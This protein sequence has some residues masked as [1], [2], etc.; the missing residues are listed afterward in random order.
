MSSSA[1]IATTASESKIGP[2][3]E[4]ATAVSSSATTGDEAAAGTAAAAEVEVI[5]AIT[6]TAPAENTKGSVITEINRH[7]LREDIA[8][9]TI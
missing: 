9:I 1:S 8:L 5:P 4:T 3:A 6:V 7:M 2:S